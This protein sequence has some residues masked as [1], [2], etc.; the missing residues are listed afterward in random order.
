LAK[1]K[2]TH[3]QLG[4]WFIQVEIIINFGRILTEC[5]TTIKLCTLP[6]LSQLLRAGHLKYRLI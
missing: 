1:L 2:A 3:T 6:K 5:G 4:A